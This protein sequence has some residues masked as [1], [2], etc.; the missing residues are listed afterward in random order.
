MMARRTWKAI[1][2]SLMAVPL[3]AQAAGG[4]PEAQSGR[5]PDISPPVITHVPQDTFRADAALRIHARVVDESGVDEVVLFHRNAGELEYRQTRMAPDRGADFYVAELPA[6]SGPRIEYFIRATDT[7]GNTLLGRLFDPYVTTVLAADE[8]VASPPS[9]AAVIPLAP[10]A[11]QAPAETARPAF[12]APGGER[13]GLPRW[14]WIGLGVVAVAVVAAGA[15]GGGGGGD[16]APPGAPD[17]GVGTV[18]ITA[19]VP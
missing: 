16:A 19:P 7:A 10:A 8:A 9:A 11:Q 15:G 13:S 1:I 5:G 18:T 6:G 12:A 17:A 4:V 2:T 14:A 3:L